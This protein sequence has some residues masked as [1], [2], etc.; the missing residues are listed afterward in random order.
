MQAFE[1]RATLIRRRKLFLAL[2]AFGVVAVVIAALGGLGTLA[3][4]ALVVPSLAIAFG[5]AA[6]FARG[7]SPSA[8]EVSV[9]ADALGVAIDGRLELPRSALRSAALASGEPL[10][11]VATTSWRTDLRLRFTCKGDARTFVQALGLPAAV[12]APTFRATLGGGSRAYFAFAAGIVALIALELVLRRIAPLG[13][14]VA[15]LLLPTWSIGAWLA[16]SAEVHVGREGISIARFG[17]RPLFLGYGEIGAIAEQ[18]D[19]LVFERRDGSKVRLGF[20]DTRWLTGERRRPTSA[21]LA[22]IR[23]ACSAFAARASVSGSEAFAPA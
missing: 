17:R 19:D 7:L 6:A 16:M 22:R 3:A 20:A 21:V 9:F 14:H 23:E 11:A 10:V 1:A 2:E 18:Y 5:G 4:I 8:R 13:P 15:I 12:P